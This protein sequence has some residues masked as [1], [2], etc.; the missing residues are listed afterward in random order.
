MYGE[1]RVTVK[2]GEGN[3]FK[4]FGKLT[5]YSDGFK[6]NYLLDGDECVMTCKGQTITQKR[7]GS[8]NTEITFIP[9]Q[10]T[11]CI[12][13]DG[14]LRGTVPVYTKNAV[15]VSGSNGV[16]VSLDYLLDGERKN[17]SLTAIKNTK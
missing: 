9:N 10:K 1:Y 6:L 14:A 5:V 2:D 17:L 7:S 15:C 13:S 12:L 3:I 16:K 8:L 4:S 11:Q